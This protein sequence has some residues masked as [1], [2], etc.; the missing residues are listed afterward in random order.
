MRLNQVF[1]LGCMIFS[2]TFCFNDE[3]YEHCKP[4][5]AYL[6]TS[7]VISADLKNACDQ[8][9]EFFYQIARE[10]VYVLYTASQRPDYKAVDAALDRLRSH[11]MDPKDIVTIFDCY[12]CYGE[13]TFVED[14][15]YCLSSEPTSKEVLFR[16]LFDEKKYECSL[17]SIDSIIST[18]GNRMSWDS[19]K[20]KEEFNYFRKQLL[21]ILYTSDDLSIICDTLRE[22]LMKK[23]Q[24]TRK[25]LTSALEQ[26][27]NN[28]QKYENEIITL[29]DKIK[30]VTAKLKMLEVQ[31]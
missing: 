2:S 24:E 1:L 7:N 6:K 15:L 21:A 4:V 14:S 30:A 25:K 20:C 8:Y 5:I 11:V 26:E 17:C 27:K 23:Q 22:Y 10:M 31:K 19:K 3:S 13:A 28:T 16:F 9:P 29:Q 12:F 18:L